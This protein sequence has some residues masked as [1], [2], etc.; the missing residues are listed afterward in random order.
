M[1]EVDGNWPTIPATAK[2]LAAAVTPHHQRRWE[3]LGL[4]AV[5]TSLAM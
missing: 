1:R 3:L 5:I 2:M 4:Y